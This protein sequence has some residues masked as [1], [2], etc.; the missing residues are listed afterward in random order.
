METASDDDTV[1]GHSIRGRHC[2][3]GTVSDDDIVKWEQSDEDTTKW[4][5]DIYLVLSS[6]SGVV[7]TRLLK[8]D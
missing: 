5:Y 7:L 8:E 4:T 6:S 1:S 3:V 2:E